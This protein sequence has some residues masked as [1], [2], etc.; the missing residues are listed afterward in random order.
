M[1]RTLLLGAAAAASVLAFAA[2]A[3]AQYGNWRTIGYKT[4]SG[5]TD[6]DTIDVRGN[7]RYRAVRLCSFNAPIRMRDFDIRFENGGHQ[8]V[9]VRQ[10][11]GAG[12]CTRAIDLQGGRR[13]IRRIKLVYEQILRSVHRPLIRVQAR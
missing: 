11:I 5:G 13:D 1:T 10:R 12:T 8:D 4:V 6:R 9:A 3:A 2:P 7:A